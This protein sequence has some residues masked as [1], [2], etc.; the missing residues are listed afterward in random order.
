MYVDY[1][2]IENIDEAIDK[3][4]YYLKNTDKLEKIRQNVIKKKHI[5]NYENIARKMA[6]NIMEL[7]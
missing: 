2:Y 4:R 3:I 5:F 7:F 1:I 6:T